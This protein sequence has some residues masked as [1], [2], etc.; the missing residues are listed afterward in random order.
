MCH[1]SAHV[2]R[3]DRQ[4]G[5][6]AK[7]AIRAFE[8]GCGKAAS[9]QLPIQPGRD[10]FCS[11]SAMWLHVGAAMTDGNIDQRCRYLM[12]AVEIV[13]PVRLGNVLHTT[14]DVKHRSV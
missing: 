7:T 11:Q 10:D 14:Q 8:A 12:N 13:P 6:L 1:I 9:L 4:S 3:L 5:V 2:S